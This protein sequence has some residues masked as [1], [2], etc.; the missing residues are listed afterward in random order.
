MNPQLYLR[1][2]DDEETRGRAGCYPAITGSNRRS[3]R[4]YPR[5][6]AATAPDAVTTDFGWRC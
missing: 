2:C 3:D 5:F 1:T 4:L 6:G